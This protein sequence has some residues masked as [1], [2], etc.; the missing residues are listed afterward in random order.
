MLLREDGG[1]GGCDDD[2]LDRRRG[3]L[4]GLEDAPRAVE[5]GGDDLLLGVCEGEE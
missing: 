5:R 2:A 1:E 4:D 3:P